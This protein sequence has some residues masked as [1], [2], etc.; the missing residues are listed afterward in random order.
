MSRRSGGG[1]S[2]GGRGGGGSSRSMSGA[3]RPPPPRLPQRR[4]TPPAPK[5]TS[6]GDKQPAKSQSP[7]V[8][9]RGKRGGDIRGSSSRS[10][11]RHH[12][13]LSP[14]VGDGRSEFSCR[15]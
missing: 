5:P 1:R 11:G 6:P 8:S 7:R 4:E 10:S 14:R 12:G 15:Q 3:S 9:S 13:R 2:S